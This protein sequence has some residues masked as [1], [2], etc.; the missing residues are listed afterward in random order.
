MSIVE[1]A[2]ILA[3][4]FALAFLTET[5]VEYFVGT[6]MDKVEKLKPWKWLLM[7]VAAG[8][9]VFLAL[10]YKLD[11]IALA[12]RLASSIT[13]VATS[14]EVVTVPGMV[15]TG[16]GLGRGSNFLHDFVSRYIMPAK[17]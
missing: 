16:L 10:F 7:Y 5:F 14:L 1:S 9:G 3:V 13:G 11:L 4:S 6:P 2:K 8:V 15:L 17:A 12:A